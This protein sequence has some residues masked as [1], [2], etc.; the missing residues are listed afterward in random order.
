MRRIFLVLAWVV[1]LAGCSLLDLAADIDEIAK[2]VHKIKKEGLIKK[3][4]PT[5][6]LKNNQVK[7]SLQGDK[8]QK[9]QQDKERERREKQM[10][11]IQKMQ[12]NKR[13]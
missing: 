7:T 12:K 3:A 2:D 9:E 13:D 4:A 8:W 6:S 11:L 1:G 5:Q 10:E